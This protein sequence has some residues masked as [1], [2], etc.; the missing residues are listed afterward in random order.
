M[1]RWFSY[2]VIFIFF[3]SLHDQRSFFEHPVMWMAGYMFI[4][5]YEAGR[6][7]KKLYATASSPSEGLIEFAGE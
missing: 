4:V 1:P 3:E 5:A 2:P 7:P 6:I